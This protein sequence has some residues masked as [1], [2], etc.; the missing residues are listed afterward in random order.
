VSYLGETG[1]TSAVYR[2]FEAVEALTRPTGAVRFTAPGSV[3]RGEYGLFRW[4][5]EPRA[6]GPAA[7]FHR[8]FSEAFYILAGTVRIFDGTAWIDA[9]EGDFAYVPRGGI[10]AFRNDSD[11]DAAM[12]ILFAPGI[13]RE[14]FFEVTTEIARSGRT[15]S[16]KEWAAIYAEHD[17]V[18][19]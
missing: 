19:V 5:M 6:G 13:A 2:A 18:M 12:L 8:T 9:T 3:T 4:E 16:P 7:H 14:R 11:H 17:Q 15:P 10:H 1:E